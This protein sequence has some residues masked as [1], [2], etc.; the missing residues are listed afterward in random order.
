MLLHRIG[1]VGGVPDGDEV[2]RD[3]RV[4]PAAQGGVRLQPSLRDAFDWLRIRLRRGYFVW[5][6]FAQTAHV[7]W[8]PGRPGR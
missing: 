3:H 5:M 1:R 7:T 2:A 4:E 6:D 8:R